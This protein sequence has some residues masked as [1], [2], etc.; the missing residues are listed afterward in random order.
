MEMRAKR[1]KPSAPTN[2]K[3]QASSSASTVQHS[4]TKKRISERSGQS[5]KSSKRVKKDNDSV[6][7]DADSK[8]TTSF[9]P[10]LRSSPS[11]PTVT[12][13]RLLCTPCFY[14][15][16]EEGQKKCCVMWDSP[17]VKSEDDKFSIIPE[18]SLEASKRNLEPLNRLVAAYISN[19]DDESL[20]PNF[21]KFFLIRDPDFKYEQDHSRPQ[22]SALIITPQYNTWTMRCA[23]LGGDVDMSWMKPT[24]KKRMKDGSENEWCCYICMEQWPHSDIKIGIFAS[25]LTINTC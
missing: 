14:K 13:M 7:K 25:I 20:M 10:P 8:P 22:Y 6:M 19:P 2:N 12:N 16:D 11:K 15:Y 21:V 9:K 3:Q 1:S 23:F 18:G 24:L 4:S 5:E 17:D